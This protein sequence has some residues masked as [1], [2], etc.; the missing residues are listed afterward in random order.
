MNLHLKNLKTHLRCVEVL[1]TKPNKTFMSEKYNVSFITMDGKQ[2][3]KCL[4]NSLSIL[5]KV[6]DI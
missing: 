5:Q 3:N 4:R 6:D 2:N 1:D